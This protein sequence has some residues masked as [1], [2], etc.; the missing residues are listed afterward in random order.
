MLILFKDSQPKSYKP[1]EVLHCLPN[2]IP[3]EFR[4]YF[5]N[6]EIWSH[7]SWSYASPSSWLFLF[8]Y[9][10]R[11]KLIITWENT[12]FLKKKAQNWWEKQKHTKEHQ[13]ISL[14]DSFISRWKEKNEEK[15]LNAECGRA[16][17]VTLLN[18]WITTFENSLKYFEDCFS[19]NKG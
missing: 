16:T 13:K 10:L 12:T 1:F 9:S 17:E 8:F 4:K 7:V 14:S 6:C 3:H 15:N 19:K 18:K 2:F 11:N 5:P